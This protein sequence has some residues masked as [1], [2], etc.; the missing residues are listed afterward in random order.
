MGCAGSTRVDPGSRR[1]GKV[2]MKVGGA[3][4]CPPILLPV[5]KRVYVQGLRQAERG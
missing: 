5:Y 1:G 2:Q 4:L 3:N